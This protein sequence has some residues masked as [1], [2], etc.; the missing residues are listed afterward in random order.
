MTNSNFNINPLVSL[1]ITTFNHGIY[2]SDAIKSVYAQTYKNIE[3]IVIDDGST[4]GTQNI[5]SEFEN[6]KYIYQKNSGLSAARNKGIEASSGEF[7][8]FLDADDWL[9]ET[10]IQTNLNKLREVYE[11]VFIAGAYRFYYEEFACF[12]KEDIIASEIHDPYS[13]L[14]RIN[15]IGMHAAVMYRRM[16]FDQFRYDTSLKSCEDYDLYLRISR[17]YK[18]LYQPNV[19]AVYRIHGKNMSS[20]NLRMLRYALKVL[21]RQ[22]KYLLTQEEKES[23][24]LGISNWRKY[25]AEKQFEDLR[26]KTFYWK[27]NVSF[28]ELLAMRQL[29]VALFEQFLKESNTQNPF[30]LKYIIKAGIKYIFR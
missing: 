18:I 6:V 9:L 5:I 11:A 26:L 8:V 30:T 4:D 16:I 27:K 20:N 2:L 22:N 23:Y 13:S 25:Y 1:I 3:I 10:A 14:L 17:S 24:N 7:L 12:G 19:I 15:F 28:K 29:D 21:K